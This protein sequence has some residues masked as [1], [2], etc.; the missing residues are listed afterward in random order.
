[1]PS[2]PHCGL[3][4]TPLQHGTTRAPLELLAPPD[5]QLLL[6]RRFAGERLRLLLLLRERLLLRL[7]LLRL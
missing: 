5:G 7:R 1:M 6:R 4:A 3:A 2:S